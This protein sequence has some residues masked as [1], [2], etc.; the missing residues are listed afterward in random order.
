M[1][2]GLALRRREPDHGVLLEGADA[3]VHELQGRE[4]VGP[5]GLR[6]TPDLDV[7]HER[8]PG[9][10][11]RP[12]GALMNHPSAR[13]PSREAILLLQSNESAARPIMTEGELE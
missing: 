1:K 8:E 4:P 13:G 5:A 6:P 7:V 11:V 12:D 9:I 3:G 2:T 10:R